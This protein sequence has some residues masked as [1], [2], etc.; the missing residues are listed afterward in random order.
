VSYFNSSNQSNASQAVFA[1]ARADID[2]RP[3]MRM[4]YMWMVLGLLT[5]AGISAYIASSMETV[6]AVANA[7]PFIIIAQFALVMGLSWGISKMSPVVAAVLFFVYAAMNGLTFGVMFFAYISQGSGAAITNAFL[8]TAGLFGAMTVIGF[9]TKTDL[10]KWGS[11]LMMALIGLVI[12]MIVNIFLGSSMLDYVIS[13][14][15]VL[16]FTALTAWDTQR[17]KEM[18]ML[19]EFSE[20]GDNLTRFAI[21]GALQLYLD[22]INIF[23]FLLRLFAGGNRD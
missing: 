3:L 11:F 23:I 12:A 22:F 20:Y 10:T 19:P 15:G 16:I 14:I 21:I 8:T 6:V 7:F 18:A 5:T 1:P 17:I 13:V 9:T 2:V 4:V